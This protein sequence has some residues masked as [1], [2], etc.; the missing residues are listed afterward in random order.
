MHLNYGLF[1]K[2]YVKTVLIKTV[3]TDMFLAH[4]ILWVAA[5]WIVHHTGR[6]RIIWIKWPSKWQEWRNV[7]DFL[8]RTGV[9]EVVYQ[10]S[11]RTTDRPVEKW[12]L[13]SK[14]F[15]VRT[16]IVL[17]SKQWIIWWIFETCTRRTIFRKTDQR[18]AFRNG[19]PPIS[20]WNYYTPNR[21]NICSIKLWYEE[22]Q[23]TFV[24][25]LISRNER[26]YYI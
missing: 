2:V 22:P 7:K 1:V 21:D 20:C 12:S 4:R 24:S 19:Y 8:T 15:I 18:A 9:T 6:F 14:W 5:F 16:M 11:L 10:P 25:R 23:S 3:A 17:T 26:S 13:S